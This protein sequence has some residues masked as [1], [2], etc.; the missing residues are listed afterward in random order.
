MNAIRKEIMALPAAERLPYALEVI[1]QLTDQ[2]VDDLARVQ[3]QMGV[4]GAQAKVILALN[5]AYPRTLSREGLLFRLHGPGCEVGDTI[6]GVYV[7]HIRRKHPDLIETV[8]GVGYRLRQQID[9]FALTPAKTE[10][11]AA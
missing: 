3:R 10:G 7:S 6:V 5:A 1:Q 2:S 9:L 11:G 4:T 8:W